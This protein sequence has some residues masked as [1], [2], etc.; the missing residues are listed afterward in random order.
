VAPIHYKYVFTFLELPFF[1]ILPQK[2]HR[3]KDVI[4]LQKEI[5]N[6]YSNPTRCIVQIE[7]K[8]KIYLVVANIFRNHEIYEVNRSYLKNWGNWKFYFMLC[9]KGKLL[10]YEFFISINVNEKICYKFAT[11]RKISFVPSECFPNKIEKK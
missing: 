1:Q 6:T 8:K 9:W 3:R 7:P 5:K 2:T 10:G 4:K 11:K